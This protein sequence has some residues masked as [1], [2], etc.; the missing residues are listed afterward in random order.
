MFAG[1]KQTLNSYGD[2]K[3]C[4]GFR[5]KAILQMNSSHIRSEI[6]KTTRINV[7][8]N[9]GFYRE[10]GGSRFFHIVVIYTTLCVVKAP[11]RIIFN[12][13]NFDA[14]VDDYLGTSCQMVKSHAALSETL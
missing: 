6:L 5:I 3:E 12:V 7:A 2:I 9:W 11:K 10:D 14:P 13:L 8:V 4:F 1:L